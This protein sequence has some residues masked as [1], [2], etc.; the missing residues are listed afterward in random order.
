MNKP[1]KIML[2]SLGILFGCIF[3][4]KSFGNYMLKRYLASRVDVATVSEMAAEYSPWQPQEKYYGTLRPVQGVNVT[5]EIAGLVEKIYTP[6]GVTVKKGDLLVQLNAQPDIALLHSLQANTALAK[7]TLTR[8]TAQFAIQAVSKA[9]VDA[10]AAN[11]KSLSAQTAQQAAIVEKK[12]IRAPFSG[13]L[14]IVTI[15][16]GQFINP[17]DTVG[18]LQELDNIF[19]D[20]SVP[21]QQLMI[22]KVG[23]PVKVTVDTFPKL[24]F[25]GKITT[26]NPVI[27]ANTRNVLVEATLPNPK[28]ELTPGMFATVLVKT[29][30]PHKYITLP[31]TAITFNSYGDVIYTIEEKGK[32]KKG[33]PILIATQRFVT[34]GETRGDQ[35][36]ILNGIKVGDRVVTSGQLKLKN[37]MQVIINNSVVPTNNPAPITKE[38]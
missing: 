14:G 32:D 29:G 34:T 28:F 8:D 30:E 22:M 24:V 31:L 11:Y 7:I 18:P 36:T 25:T 9:V 21:Q 5:T 37:G 17:G 33:N 19:I 20:F 2:I 27:D 35:V 12:M 15:N 38:E 16:E 3:L 10:D 4:Y 23:Q 1:M 26:I 6:S 13:R